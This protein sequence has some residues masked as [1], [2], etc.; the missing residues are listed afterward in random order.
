MVDDRLL[1]LEAKR[2]G[3]DRDAVAKDYRAKMGQKVLLDE[4]AERH[5]VPS[6]T[7][8]DS[9]LKTLFVRMNTQVTARHLIAQSFAQA[10]TYRNR[11]LKGETFEKLAK[12]AFSDRVLRNNGG[13]LKSFTVDEMEPAFEEA[14]YELPLMEISQPIKVKHGYSVLQV[15]KRTTKPL[16]TE[17]QF[18]EKKGDLA[19]YQRTRNRPIAFQQFADSIRNDVLQ[20][21]FLPGQSERFFEAYKAARDSEGPLVPAMK[22]ML[23]DQSVRQP[24]ATTTEGSLTLEKAAELLKGISDREMGWVRNGHDL[25]NLISG[26]MAREWMLKQ[27]HRERLDRSERYQS[28]MEDEFDLY[29]VQRVSDTVVA[30]DRISEDTL[31]AFYESNQNLFVRPEA[32]RLSGI[33]VASEKAAREIA[34]LLDQGQPFSELARRFSEH[35]ASAERGGDLGV[36]AR[37]QLGP[38]VNAIWSLKQ[39]DWVGPTESEGGTYSFFMVTDR[40]ASKTA[41]YETIKND[42]TEEYKKMNRTQILSDVTN[43][44]RQKTVV[45]IDEEALLKP[46]SQGEG[47]L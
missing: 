5:I 18:I 29:L 17:Q 3:L 30:T 40:L 20:L 10:E 9:E 15:L 47:V 8:S 11:L 32:I 14:A 24:L 16:L 27:A 28:S 37:S 12:E 31:R 22:V 41:P 13:L 33:Q 1:L 43:R 39:G 6:V 21:S 2:Q 4:Y 34:G 36:F 38:Q 7:V 23:D 26:M 45:T 19:K 25:E 42:V 46:R 35:R 44:L